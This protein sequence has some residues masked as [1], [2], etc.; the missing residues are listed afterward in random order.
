MRDGRL[1]YI[2]DPRE[3]QWVAR[4]QLVSAAAVLLIFAGIAFL[5]DVGP[6]VDPPALAS[7]PS[8]EG[9]RQVEQAPVVPGAA[10][11]TPSAKR[12][13]GPP[14]DAS[15]AGYAEGA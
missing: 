11:A 10:S 8:A 15:P 5:A 13:P 14:Q 1:Y 12:E 2:R 3:R 9:E 7:T 6:L 4:M